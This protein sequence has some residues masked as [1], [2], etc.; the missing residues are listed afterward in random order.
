MAIGT[1]WEQK[2]LMAWTEENQRAA[3]IE[4]V[5]AVLLVKAVR[6]GFRL[7]PGEKKASAYPVRQAWASR[8]LLPLQR[9]QRERRVLLQKTRGKTVQRQFV[10]LMFL[11]HQLTSQRYI[12]LVPR[13]E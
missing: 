1:V 2:H 5:V 13:H 12:L 3:P 6:T 4:A 10:D 8:A 7:A 9:I 11:K